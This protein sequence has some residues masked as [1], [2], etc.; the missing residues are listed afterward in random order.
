MHVGVFAY[1]P[2]RACVKLKYLLHL[3]QHV[4][5]NQHLEKAIVLLSHLIAT[6]REWP[7]E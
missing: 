2:V 3:Q 1:V 6:T 7:V 5:V 4:A